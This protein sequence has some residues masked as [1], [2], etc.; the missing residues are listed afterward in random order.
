MQNN[1]TQLITLIGQGNQKA[2][3]QYFHLLELPLLYFAGKLMNDTRQA[4]DVVL[5]AF[6]KLWERRQG[7][8]SQQAARSFL[9][10]TVRNEAL[11]YIKRRNMMG[12]AHR[13]IR[14]T[15]PDHEE[16]I[17]YRMQQAE[18]LSRVYAQMKQLPE[19]YRQILEWVY[20][21]ELSTAVIARKLSMEESSVRAA[22][23]RAIALLRKTFSET[24]LLI[25][26]FLLTNMTHYA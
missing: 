14:A 1:E 24:D 2:F 15:L 12:V 23:T 6:Q 25:L 8:L 10:T 4:E 26:A 7:F 3:Q 21:E 9:Y 20:I 16:Y 22:K 19:K 18:I 5:A 17:E 13:E 11:N